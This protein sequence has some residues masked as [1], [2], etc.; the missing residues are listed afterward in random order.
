MPAH[1]RVL[2]G[3]KPTGTPHLGNYLGAIRPAIQL[4]ETYDDAFLFIADLHALTI[5]QDSARL[6]EMGYSVAATWL[7]F[8]LDPKKVTF[9]RQSDIP[10]TVQ[11]AW[12]LAC[13]TPLGTLNR[14]HSF[15]DAQAKGKSLMT[16]STSGLY[17]YPI[18]MSRG[19]PRL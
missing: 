2:T 16:T 19:H 10:E 3:I 5:K 13:A 7:A 4:T 14:A 6:T 12:V 1:R 9:Y 11:L 17:S 8:G 15:K 18:L